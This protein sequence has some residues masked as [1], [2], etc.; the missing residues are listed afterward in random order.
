LNG[1]SDGGC[2]GKRQRRQRQRQRQRRRRRRRRRNSRRRKRRKRR[3]G[4]GERAQRGGE[5]GG[6]QSIDPSRR[7]RQP[8]S[9]S[10]GFVDVGVRATR[11]I[12]ISARRRR[13]TPEL[14]LVGV[15][16][17]GALA[18]PDHDFH[19]LIRMFNMFRMFGPH[20]ARGHGI[21]AILRISPSGDGPEFNSRT[22]RVRDCSL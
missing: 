6:L 8:G 15:G 13:A 17:G 12:R 2:R 5:G 4:A 19:G 11:G 18:N 21:P 1:N 3:R 7:R 16:V 9:P 22:R 10:P 20:A 14:D